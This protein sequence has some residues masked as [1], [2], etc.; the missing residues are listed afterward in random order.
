MVAIVRLSSQLISPKS[1]PL[2]TY[3]FVREPIFDCQFQLEY[4]ELP[5]RKS[6]NPESLALTV[7][8]V[9]C[10]ASLQLHPGFSSLE[11]GNQLCEDH[12]R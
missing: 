3:S 6:E 8:P 1:R 10:K 4:R 7:K 5:G 9:K 2:C 11:E 12:N